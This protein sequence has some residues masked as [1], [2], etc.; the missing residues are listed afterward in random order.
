MLQ[1][2]LTKHSVNRI[3]IMT[4]RSTSLPSSN[5]VTRLKRAIPPLMLASLVCTGLVVTKAAAAAESAPAAEPITYSKNPQTL[6]FIERMVSEHGFDKK[7]LNALFDS[8]AKQQS[9][10]DAI[11]R[12]A[13]KMLTWG[14]YRKI[15]VT[16]TRTKDGKAFIKDN[17]E[18][19]KRAEETYG[20]PKEIIAAIIG[21]ETRYGQ[22]MGRYRVIDALSTLSFD[23]P[24]RSKF[25]SKE[26]E[27]LLLL[28]REQKFE[29]LELT[30]SYAGAMG[31]GQFIPSSYRSYAVDFDGDGQANIISNLEDA[32]G[33]VANYFAKHGWRR[34]EP[35][36][37]PVD[38]ED[39]VDPKLL[40]ES[41][42]PV[43]KLSDLSGVG[44][45]EQAGVAA[46]AP[47]RLLRFEGD[48]GIEFWLST[49]NFYVITRYNHS[50][51]YAL[52]VFQLSQALAES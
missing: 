11:S 47:V 49:Y 6:A 14:E 5:I 44:L 48:D 33:S 20:V 43:Q 9:I 37:F 17:L 12:P 41:R 45:S 24:A 18:T 8:A 1:S 27:Q 32:I 34:G 28:S 16:E 25:F 42:K 35:V 7:Y 13:E 38:V 21:V 15:F 22:Y 29:P 52:A 31:F 50:D 23:Y 19:L 3:L 2:A 36:A 46:D 30:G 40:P 39:S 4:A 26:L 51:R 10:I